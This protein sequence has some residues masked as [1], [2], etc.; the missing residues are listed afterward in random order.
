[1]EYVTINGQPVDLSGNT[2]TLN[3]IEQD[4][5]IVVSFREAKNSIF[6]DEN[7]YIL[8]YFIVIAAV[9]VAFVIAKIVLYFVRKNRKKKMEA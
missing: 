2:L 1:M 6:D 7:S 4:Y 5:D 3:D 9:F 8:I